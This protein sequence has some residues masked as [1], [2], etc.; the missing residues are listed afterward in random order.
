MPFAS[1]YRI[2]TSGRHCMAD[3][4]RNDINVRW[5]TVNL[6]VERRKS[7]RV[8]EGRSS[9]PTVNFS[10]LIAS[11]IGSRLTLDIKSF[12]LIVYK[13]RRFLRDLLVIAYADIISKPYTCTNSQSSRLRP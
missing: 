8:V 13:A 3:C 11:T 6:V 12:A 2:V 7:N 10:P 1:P 4:G 9:C 5:H